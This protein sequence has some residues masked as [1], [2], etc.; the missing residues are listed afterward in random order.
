RIARIGSSAE[1]SRFIL[2]ELLQFLHTE[3]VQIIQW[4]GYVVHGSAWRDDFLT[5][6]YVGARWWF[7]EPPRNVGNGGF[8]L[9]SRRLL[10]ALQDETIKA[11]D[12]EDNVICLDKRDLLEHRYGIRIAPGAVADAY[13]FEGTQPSGREFGFHRLFNFP[14][15]H[16]ER[17][18]AAV[19]A[20]VP[21]H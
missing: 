12:P 10:Q 14:H 20:M 7:R 21:H 13:A 1:Y 5:Y 19:M 2:K 8:S 16:D 3:Y 18:L 4:D 11:T 9:R 15:V 17:E 6:D